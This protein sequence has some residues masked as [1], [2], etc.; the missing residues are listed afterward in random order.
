ME[1]GG[2]HLSIVERKISLLSAIGQ[3]LRQDWKPK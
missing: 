2:N 1:L 3:L